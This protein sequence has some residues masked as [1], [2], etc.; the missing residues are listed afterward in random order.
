MKIGARAFGMA[1]GIVLGLAGLVGTLFSLWFGA[2]GTIGALGVVYIGYARSYPGALI[3]L[4]W[5]LVYGFLGGWLI[6][7]VYNR[8]SR[9][10]LAD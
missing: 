4:V 7:F 2:G 1:C 10:S 3:A 9:G 8:L 5:G 6:A